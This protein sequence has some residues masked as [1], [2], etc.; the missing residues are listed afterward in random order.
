MPVRLYFIRH[1]ETEWS[2][3]GRHTSRTDLPLTERGE[4]DARELG[5][6]LR[7]TTFARVFSSPRQR[8]R[9]T[10]ALA[11]LVAAAE[12]EADLAEWDYGEYEGKR[13]VEIRAARPDWNLFRDGCPGGEMPAEV[14]ARADR[15]I[16]HLRAFEGN[17]ALFSHGHFGCVLATRWIGLPVIE[18]QHFHLATVSLT[19]LGYESSQLKVPVIELG[20]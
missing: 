8:A 16:T 14:S 19:I 17:V 5:E 10:C 2:R 18:G 7:A 11:A 12:I 6:R 4:Q 20:S 15:V 1:G 9:Q 13:S 3:S